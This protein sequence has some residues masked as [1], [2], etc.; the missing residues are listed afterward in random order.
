MKLEV[1]ELDNGIKQIKLTGRLDI[2]GTNE[3]ENSFTAHAASKKQVVLVD[4]AEVEFITSYGMRIL[5]SNA[6]SLARRGGKMVLYRPAPTVKEVLV[7]AGIGEIISIYDDFDAA[8]AD[9]K[10]T[11][12]D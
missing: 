6:K 10:A 8:C 1:T 12:I 7:M 5:V 4:M 3:I 11:D 2:P 9:L